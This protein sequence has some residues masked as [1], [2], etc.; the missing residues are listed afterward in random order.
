MPRLIKPMSEDTVRNAIPKDKQFA[1][2]DGGGLFL[3]VRPSGGKLW[4]LKYRFD[5]KDKK[6]ALGA[7]PAITLEE[8]R[9]KRDAAKELVLQ[10]FDPTEIRQQEKTRSKA[11]HLKAKRIPSVRAT[12]DGK[13]EIW[14]GNNT[15][16]LKLDEARFTG[17]L[18]INM[19]R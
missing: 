11:E 8:A 12:F 2:F 18:L 5:N 9:I 6:L 4:R 3:L 13:I 17:T 19:T 10:C 7:Y 15:M 14:K 1:L 16:R